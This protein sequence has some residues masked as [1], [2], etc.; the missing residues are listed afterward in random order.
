MLF[1]LPLLG[2]AVF[3][4]NNALA[5]LFLGRSSVF[6]SRANEPLLVSLFIWTTLVVELTFLIALLFSVLLNV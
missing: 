2:L 6:E 3:F 5:T 1:L 4:L